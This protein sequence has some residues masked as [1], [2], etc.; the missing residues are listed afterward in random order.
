[1][2]QAVPTPSLEPYLRARVIN[3]SLIPSHP[4]RIA[5]TQIRPTDDTGD[6]D[7]LDFLRSLLRL[8]FSPC[9]SILLT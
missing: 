8:A 2:S 6:T 4:P 5:R 1:M 7:F 9:V 3:P